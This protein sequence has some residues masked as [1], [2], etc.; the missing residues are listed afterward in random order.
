MEAEE[1]ALALASAPERRE[2]PE[3][4]RGD[5]EEVEE[6]EASR[7]SA[8]WKQ[9]SAELRRESKEV[10]ESVE[11]R[12]RLKQNEI[13]EASVTSAVAFRLAENENGLTGLDK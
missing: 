9:D 10:V 11:S 2:L 6:E 5:R 4:R 12:F 3:D 13:K 8:N 1:S 7:V